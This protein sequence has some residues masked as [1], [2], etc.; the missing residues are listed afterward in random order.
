LTGE[1]LAGEDCE[2]K[3]VFSTC[4]LV[5]FEHKERVRDEL[6]KLDADM[7]KQFPHLAKID[8]SL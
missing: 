7:C 2:H 5:L 4:S 1:K 3:V 6:K 8:W